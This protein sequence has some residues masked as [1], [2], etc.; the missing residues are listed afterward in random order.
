LILITSHASLLTSNSVLQIAQILRTE[1]E[2]AD[3]LVDA[4]ADVD[5]TGGA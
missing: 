3:T 1:E 5:T 2:D 4:D